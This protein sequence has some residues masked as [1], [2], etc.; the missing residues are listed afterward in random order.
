MVYSGDSARPL[1]MAANGLI[2]IIAASKIG[3]NFSPERRQESVLVLYAVLGGFASLSMHLNPSFLF[4]N[5]FSMPVAFGIAAF[6]FERF[7]LGASTSESLASAEEFG[8]AS[9]SSSSSSASIAAPTNAMELE[10]RLR[11]PLPLVGHH[12]LILNELVSTSGNGFHLHIVTGARGVGKSRLV[13]EVGYADA[14]VEL[15]WG[16]CGEDETQTS[17]QVIRQALSGIVGAHRFG[18]KDV[19]GGLK[20]LS[21]LVDFGGI[22]SLFGG[23]DDSNGT[24][25]ARL[26]VT[27][28]NIL[29]SRPRS[30][31]LALE[32]LQY[33]DFESQE[34]LI[35]LAQ[36]A[37]T[38]GFSFTLLLVFRVDPGD[39]EV[40][41]LS[42][43]QPADP[44]RHSVTNL[45]Q[46]DVDDLLTRVGFSAEF[47]LTAGREMHAGTTGNPLMIQIVLQQIDRSVLLPSRAGDGF[48]L[49]PG[50]RLEIPQELAAGIRD[51]AN[52]LAPKHRQT[53]QLA[54][55]IGISF[56]VDL[57][58]AALRKDEFAVV[59]ELEELV[60]S[61][62][63]L[64]DP[65]EG[66]FS[67]LSGALL[68][69]FQKQMGSEMTRIAYIRLAEALLVSESNDMDIVYQFA[70]CC[71]LSGKR[72]ED[73]AFTACKR[74]AVMAM[75]AY[76]VSS[77]VRFGRIALSLLEPG[78]ED[79]DLRMTLAKAL[80]NRNP[81]VDHALIVETLKPL[82]ANVMSADASVGKNQSL[83]VQLSLAYAYAGNSEKAITFADL[84]LKGSIPIKDQCE[85]LWA[86]GFALL[87]GKS[88]EKG[89]FA[90]RRGISILREN[91]LAHPETECKLLNVLASNLLAIGGHA[92]DEEAGAVLQ[93]SYRI[94]Q[95]A[96]M[97]LSQAIAL[98]MRGRLLVKQYEAKPDNGVLEEARKLI[99]ANDILNV[100][101]GSTIGL[102]LAPQSLMKIAKLKK[103]WI[104]LLRLGHE[105][106]ERS[107]RFN[108]DKVRVIAEDAIDEASK[109]L[110][111]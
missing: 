73:K 22:G 59:T 51:R 110:L 23:G 43:L 33:A 5:A 6:A 72:M 109:N 70:E 107:R 69:A 111:E 41:W 66:N 99:E 36:A 27:I 18:A 28:G 19:S 31:V 64:D 26:A 24:S 8:A 90:L 57:L 50:H 67:F 53:L 49:L 34:L 44:Q 29:T 81:Y 77:A 17:F 105:L 21:D 48:S 55:L 85:A 68:E 10:R 92:N 84:V 96:R 42:R 56:R 63:L 7:Y 61:G 38:E 54:S 30:V 52:S 104:E 4:A 1:F 87:R 80:L 102:L 89:A 97:D 86:K 71:V 60:A 106:L 94:A 79:V 2:L 45:L 98:G 11:L 25:P 46:D 15:L 47:R 82:E 100:K 16:T 12:N 9:S 14:N 78:A 101:L 75:D 62:F 108:D 76:Q 35:A 83:L 13:R 65:A 93:E 3:K 91:K 20:G 103:E 37:K 58:A 95:A 88:F 40:S 32:D 39:A 74:A